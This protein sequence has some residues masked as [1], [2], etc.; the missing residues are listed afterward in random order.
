MVKY[1]KVGKVDCFFLNNPTPAVEYRGNL[2]LFRGWGDFARMSTYTPNGKRLVRIDINNG[3]RKG[4][5]IVLQGTDKK[6]FEI[7]ASE[8]KF[9]ELSVEGIVLDKLG[10]LE[11]VFSLYPN[12]TNILYRIRSG[13][14]TIN[15]QR[16]VS[17]EIFSKGYYNLDL[18]ANFNYV[19]GYV[20][21]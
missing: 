18:P 1:Y 5:S 12:M 14:I 3:G 9:I 15:Y 19:L 11:Y 16:K 7:H 20:E 2:Y 6:V 13:N 4:S 10:D 8:A 17:K 21:F